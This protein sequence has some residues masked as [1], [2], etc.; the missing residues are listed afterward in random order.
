M[1][2]CSNYPKTALD[3][4]LPLR[5]K[6]VS[7]EAFMLT[8]VSSSIPCF[9]HVDVAAEMQCRRRQKYLKQGVDSLQ[10]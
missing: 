8:F 3:S 7:G 10:F 2:D 4:S 1:S 9:F 6:K 5:V